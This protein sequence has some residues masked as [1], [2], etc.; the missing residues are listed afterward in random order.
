MKKLCILLLL[1][2]G[3][4]QAFGMKSFKQRLMPLLE[5]QNYATFFDLTKRYSHVSLCKLFTKNEKKQAL[6]PVQTKIKQND[7]I[8]KTTENSSFRKTAWWMLPA[9]TAL[10]AATTDP[11]LVATSLAG[12]TAGSFGFKH[13]CDLFASRIMKNEY[14]TIWKKLHDCFGIKEQELKTK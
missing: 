6:E 10:L 3:T 9:S 2:A 5:S 14:T 1:L 13:Q 4:H 8:I 7:A 11:I 12:I